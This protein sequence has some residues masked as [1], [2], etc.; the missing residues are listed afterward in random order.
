MPATTVDDVMTHDIVTISAERTV[1]D[2]AELMRAADIGALVVTEQAQL[3][4]LGTDRDLV[5]RVLADGDGPQTPVRQACSPDLVVVA[6]DDAV[7][8]A[9]RVMAENTVRRLP[10]VAG[11]QVV[12]IVSLG[13]LAVARDPGSV[14]GRVSAGAPYA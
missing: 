9:A 5:V 13:D 8:D 6:P 10:V 1:R 4:G 12:G 7:A 2:A 3:V 11:D 14:L